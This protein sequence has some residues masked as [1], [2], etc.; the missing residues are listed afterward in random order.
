MAA[1]FRRIGEF[2]EGKEDWQQYVERLGHFFAAN[3][4]TEENKKHSVFLS[5][6]GPNVYKLLRSLISPAKPGDKSFQELVTAMT[7]HHSPTPSE[8]LRYKFHSR[9]RKRIETCGEGSTLP[10]DSSVDSGIHKLSPQKKGQGGIS[11]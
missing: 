8:I 6:M 5:I 10:G 2:E 4:I 9:F 3:G 7:Q 1:T 11:C